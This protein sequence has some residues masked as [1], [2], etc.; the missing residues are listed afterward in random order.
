MI[1]LYIGMSADLLHPGHLNIIEQARKLL[2]EKG[3]G[4]LIVGLLTDKAIASY[5]R[6]P[7]MTWEQRKVVVENVKGV[8]KVI[9]QETLDYVPNLLKI[10]PDYVPHGDDWK[11][12]VQAQTRQRIVEIMNQWGGKV[13]SNVFSVN[14]SH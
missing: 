14:Y 8:T 2:E 12:G 6:L 4:E 1:K 7:Y 5:K 13:C 10:K 11:T 9:P 3:G